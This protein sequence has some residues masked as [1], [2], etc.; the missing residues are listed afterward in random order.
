MDKQFQFIETKH[1]ESLLKK[2][3]KQIE[4]KITTLNRTI[5][6]NAHDEVI[7]EKLKTLNGEIEKIVERIVKREYTK[8]EECTTFITRK[9]ETINTSADK[10][11]K[12]LTK[13]EQITAAKIVSEIE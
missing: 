9:I 8:L 2:Q 6:S 12:Q 4:A 5:L 10:I 3:N 13:L 11:T 7:Y 1:L